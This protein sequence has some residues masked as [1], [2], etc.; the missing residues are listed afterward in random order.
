MNSFEEDINNAIKIVKNGGIILYPT[1][2]IWGIGCDATNEGAVKK[3]YKLK[4]REESKSMILLVYDEEMISNYVRKPSE[5]LLS[6]LSSQLKPTTAIFKNAKN[7]PSIIIGKDGS[8]GMRITKDKFCK[9][10]IQGLKKPLVSTSANISGEAFPKNFL[11]VSE[12]IKNGVEYIVQHRQNDFSKKA[13]SS[14]IKLNEEGKIE[15]IR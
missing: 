10:L 15:I 4:N 3:I 9:K 2:T 7:L 14:I 8:I 11:E 6:F 5:K 13:P 1:D 12:R